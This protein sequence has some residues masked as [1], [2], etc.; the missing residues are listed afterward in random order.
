M[1]NLVLITVIWTLLS[2]SNGWA[3]SEVIGHVRI[4]DG[5]IHLVRS[6]TRK[7]AEIGD[8]V[9]RRDVVETGDD[10]AVGITFIDNTVFSAGPNSS[11]ML[12][13]YD[14]DS[15]EFKGNLL[16]RMDRGTLSVVSG[17][18]ARTSPE[19]MKIKTPTAI[20]AVRG[21]TFLVRVED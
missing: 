1:K 20:L 6:E 12:E 9:Y 16:A 19:A 3:D 21:T 4:A 5:E 8:E 10:G 17:D 2:I 15:A 13:L 14:Y 11:I 18:I 7:K